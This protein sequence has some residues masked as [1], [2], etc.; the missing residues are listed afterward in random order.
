MNMK[1]FSWWYFWGREERT[2]SK[3]LP[4]ETS[5]SIQRHTYWSWDSTPGI[6]VM[7][8]LCLII[9]S[10]HLKAVTVLTQSFTSAQVQA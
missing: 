5:A 8:L 1:M 3:A 2:A 9:S 6:S 7:K 4:A 10:N